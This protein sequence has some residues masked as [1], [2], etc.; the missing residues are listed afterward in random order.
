LQKPVSTSITYLVAGSS[1]V[2]YTPPTTTNTPPTATTTS[3]RTFPTS[4]STSILVASGTSEG[5]RR[6]ESLLTWLLGL[7]LAGL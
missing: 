1:T 6:V 2:P 7:V 3:H 5:V 4:T